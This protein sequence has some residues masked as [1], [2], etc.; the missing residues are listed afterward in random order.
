MDKNNICTGCGGNM[1]FDPAIQKL[2]CEYCGSLEEVKHTGNVSE[3]DFSFKMRQQNKV[4]E[5]SVTHTCKRCGAASVTVNAALAMGTCAYCG[6]TSFTTS[7]ALSGVT[8][9]GILPFRIPQEQA[10]ELF[11][12]GI[13]RGIFTPKE[14]KQIQPEQVRGVYVPYWTFDCIATTDFSV[15]LGTYYKV[16]DKQ[17]TNWSNF[18]GRRTDAFDDIITNASPDRYNC[19]GAQQSAY[20]FKDAVP[21]SPQ[22]LAG[23][24]TEFPNILLA[25]AFETAKQYAVGQV[26]SRI[27]ASLPGDTY[28]SL[29]ATNYFSNIT[30]KLM[31]A[32]LWV[33]SYTHKGKTHLATVNGQTGKF[34]GKVP[35]SPLK[36]GIFAGVLAAIAATLLLINHFTNADNTSPAPESAPPQMTAS[37]YIS[38]REASDGMTYT[39]PYLR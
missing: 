10:V 1:I 11:K 5:G 3:K 28:K 24:E 20:N 17:Y 6:G 32:P 8:P 14:L 27:R 23:F 22:Y 19:G 34:C 9:D 29:N 25:N 7:E 35:K 30:C 26:Y 4:W 31:L 2:K 36:V 39:A 33:V 12:K 13:G 38:E 21:Y 15:M 16:G 18:N 37:E